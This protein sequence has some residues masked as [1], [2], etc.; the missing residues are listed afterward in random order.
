MEK[1]AFRSNYAS[2]GNFSSNQ[3][4]PIGI[5]A[6]L[7]IL[8][9]FFHSL[10]GQIRWKQTE[11]KETIY[12]TAGPL[13]IE[14]QYENGPDEIR[15]L[16]FKTDCG[17]TVVKSVSR[18]I[19]PLGGG[20][21]KILFNP[22]GRR[23][24]NKRTVKVLTDDLNNPEDELTLKINVIDPFRITPAFLYFEESEILES[25]RITIDVCE[26]SGYSLEKVTNP[27]GSLLH[28]SETVSG[29]SHALQVSILDAASFTRDFLQ[30]RFRKPEGQTENRLVHVFKK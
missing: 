30:L 25:K 21:L 6:V 29:N 26:D 24:L 2:Y 8:L 19:E 5:V 9:V 20:S 15:M 22:A 11:I 17:C 1:T 13:E 16:D 14:F 12:E 28:D 27:G 10:N 23:G 4:A 3:V 7:F 18:T